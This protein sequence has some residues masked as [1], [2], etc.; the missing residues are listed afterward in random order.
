MQQQQ[1]LNMP[2]QPFGKKRSNSNPGSNQMYHEQQYDDVDPELREA[3]EKLGLDEDGVRALQQQMY[4]QQAAEEAG[5]ESDI[6]QGEDK[7]GD[8]GEELAEMLNDAQ[9]GPAREMQ[10]QDEEEDLGEDE[11]EIEEQQIL[12]GGQNIE[13]EE[14]DDEYEMGADED[15][16]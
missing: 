1:M 4:E 12:R 16:D 7:E 8:E 13:D 3:A 5:L 6:G 9:R 11:D 2:N 15:G 14:Q 10:I